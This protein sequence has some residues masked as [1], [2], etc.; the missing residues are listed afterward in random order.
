M[1]RSLEE[2]R[3]QVDGSC[4]VA[5]NAAVLGDVTLQ[6]G[7]SVWYGAVLRGDLGSILLEEGSNVQDN[8]T[9][10]GDAEAPIRI[11]RD[12]SI[13]HNAVVHGATIGENTLVGMN[14]VILNGAVIGKNCIIS[15]GAMVASGAH[16]P[17]NSMIVGS[18]AK[19]VAE[20][21][22]VQAAHTREN[23]ETYRKLAILHKNSAEI[24]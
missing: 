3:P 24:K 23:A 20:V 17:D 8:C 11:G 6:P 1:I 22:P 16:F 21:H 2:K 7:C 10:H 14:A 4:F 18:P 13:G 9:L 5:D 19:A 12:V 15:A